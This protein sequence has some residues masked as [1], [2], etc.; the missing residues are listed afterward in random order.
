[1][2]LTWPRLLLFY[3]KH[4]LLPLTS[5]PSWDVPYVGTATPGEFFGPLAVLVVVGGAWI[6]LARRVPLAG[7]LAPWI[8]LP[9]L[10]LL[11]LRSLPPG[12]FAH[13][14]YLYLPSVGLCILL[15]AVAARVSRW[16]VGDRRG[17]A[18]PLVAAAVLGV[19]LSAATLASSQWWADEL[20]LFTHAHAVAPD[21]DAARNNLGVT[22]AERG[23]LR[24]A[25][26]L[27]G[28]TLRSDPRQWEAL[29]NLGHARLRLGELAEAE[30]LLEAATRLRPRRAEGHYYLGLTRLAQNRPD[31]AA[32]ALREAVALRP[33]EAAYRAA[34]AEA[35]ARRP[36]A[37]SATTSTASPSRGGPASPSQ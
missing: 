3:L 16:S 37:P 17:L 28:E 8:A 15:G 30:R 2:V 21:S 11:A 10:P 12:D 34:L 32:E 35:A 20:V 5:S 4:L 33:D 7:R 31:T 9:L 24:E 27:F 19:P 23:R 14:R 6:W 26:A 29:M 1:M 36:R 13:D 25:A 18:V 22:L